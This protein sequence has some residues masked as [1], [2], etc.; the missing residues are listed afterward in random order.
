VNTIY[1][2]MNNSKDEE[3]R[4]ILEFKE[5]EA[6][7]PEL[8]FVTKTGL[9][10]YVGVE[11]TERRKTWRWGFCGIPPDWKMAGWTTELIKNRLPELKLKD[12]EL[13]FHSTEK[14][15]EDGFPATGSFYWIGFKYY[16]PAYTLPVEGGTNSK[17][18][19]IPTITDVRRNIES[20]SDALK[21]FELA[22]ELV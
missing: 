6:F 3:M 19:Y 18:G 14:S 7:M 17:I 5:D 16:H 1:L 22:G 10:G 13:R 20:L 15:W 2:S 8:A 9:P 4:E 21:M 12:S 11:I